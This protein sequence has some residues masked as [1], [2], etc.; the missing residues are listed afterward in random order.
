MKKKW[1]AI[2]IILLFVGTSI[3]PLDD[4]HTIEKEQSIISKNSYDGISI[5]GTMG[6]NGWYVS[7]VTVILDF[8]GN[9][10]YYQIDIGAWQEYT[11]PIVVTGDRQHTVYCYYIDDEGNMSPIKSISF[12]IDAT[13]PYIS[14]FTVTVQNLLRTRWLLNATVE[15]ATS[16]VA[17]VEFYANDILVGTVTSAPYVFLLKSQCFKPGLA[18][19]IVYDSAGNYRLS[20]M[21]TLSSKSH[22]SQTQIN[23]RAQQNSQNL[24][25]GIFFNLQ[26][27]LTV[28]WNASQTPILPGETREVNITIT[29]AVNRGL[30]GRLLLQILKGKSFSIQLSIEDKPDWCEAWVDTPNMTGVITPDEVGYLY[31]SL[32]IHVNDNASNQTIGEIKM[33]ATAENMKGP[34]NIITLIHGFEQQFALVIWTGP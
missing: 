13:K 9:R 20:D 24:P 32:F 2:G 5:N 22:Q 34:F 26:F 3:A 23:L 15:D 30:Y 6:E 27:S 18:Q 17:K 8:H 25:Q 11:G 7:D 10:T 4:S 19:I 14:S 31:P 21:I 12:K 16:G 33:C 28:S 29:Y 1:L